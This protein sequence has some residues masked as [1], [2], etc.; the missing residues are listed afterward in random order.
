MNNRVRRRSLCSVVGVCVG[1]HGL[2]L[3]GGGGGGVG[4]SV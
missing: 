1:L 3:D 4:D 2:L